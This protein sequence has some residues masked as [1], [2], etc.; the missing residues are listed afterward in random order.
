[1]NA[2]K[3]IAVDFDGTLCDMAFP[4]IGAPKVGAV[5]AMKVLRALGFKI[6]IW[7][8]RC[9]HWDYDVYGGD[10]KQ[11][12]MERDKVQDMI[13][14]LEAHGIEYDE[15]DDGSRGKPSADYYIDDKG[16]R[17]EDNWM[18]I[19]AFIMSRT[20]TERV[21]AERRAEQEKGAGRVI[22]FPVPS[23]K[24]EVPFTDGSGTTA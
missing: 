4:E 22:P 12:V 24:E 9:C 11:P 6:I 20:T 21:L 17:F 10:P 14:W 13:A 2:P 3:R 7:S 19:A 5:E 23:A 18:N 8:C 16:I 1:M 15:I